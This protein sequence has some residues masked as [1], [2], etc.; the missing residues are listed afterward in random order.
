MLGFN[1]EHF[2]VRCRMPRASHA[3][4]L[5]VL[6]TAKT[7]TFWIDIAQPVHAFDTV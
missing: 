5:D 4:I 2:L 7:P 6:D 3:C 1:Y